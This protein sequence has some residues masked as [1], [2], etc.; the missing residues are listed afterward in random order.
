MHC[1]FSIIEVFNEPALAFKGNTAAVVW[2]DKP[3][4]DEAMQTIAKDF[5][6]PATTFLWPSSRINAFHVRWFAPDDEIGL[7]GHG[8]LA[9]V[10]YLAL[11]K[12]VQGEITLIY[13]DGLVQGYMK[14]D[15][16]CAIILDAISV[17]AEEAVPEVV[18][19]GLGIPLAGY[20]T[21]NNKHIVLAESEHDLKNMQPDFA[22]L[23]TS[24]TFGYAVTAPGEN[25]DFVSRTIVPHVQQLEDPATGSS[26]AALVPFWAGRTGNKQMLAYQLSQRGGKFVCEL[27]EAKVVLTGSFHMIAEGQLL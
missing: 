23:R 9:A 13:Q 7:C 26:H 5:N 15:N 8:S 11:R 17:I 10:V 18:K 12:E 27:R 6:Q 1:P 19:E 20:F 14:S 16:A 22:R 21:T 24:K 2:L 4:T 25:V 3:L